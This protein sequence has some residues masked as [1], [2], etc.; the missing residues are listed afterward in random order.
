[1]ADPVAAATGA[2][3][4]LQKAAGWALRRINPTN[5]ALAW[6]TVVGLSMFAPAAAVAATAAAIPTNAGVATYLSSAFSLAA[7]GAPVAWQAAT[8]AV[9]SGGPV[10]LDAVAQVVAPS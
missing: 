5:L 1:M 3:N 7:S 6:G 10:A 4:R 2:A 8:A 9:T